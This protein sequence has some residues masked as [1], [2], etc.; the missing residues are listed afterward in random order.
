MAGWA[1]VSDFKSFS[2]HGQLERAC[3][4]DLIEWLDWEWRK[5]VL[6]FLKFLAVGI[7]VL[8]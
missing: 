1:R 3:W 6:I 5:E 8:L 4:K 7:L 2:L